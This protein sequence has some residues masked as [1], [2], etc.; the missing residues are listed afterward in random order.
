VGYII[1][2]IFG[3]DIGL[4]IDYC[5]LAKKG[6]MLM[7]TKMG[8]SY[9]QMTGIYGL[10]KREGVSYESWFLC[11]YTDKWRNW[12]NGRVVRI[13]EE[14]TVYKRQGEGYWFQSDDEAYYV[15]RIVNGKLNGS[16]ELFER[17]LK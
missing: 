4:I 9:E 12:R 13:N 3:I 11:D 17:L 15:P 2:L 14:R 10:L 7:K 5:L 1:F 16:D 8:L 6:E